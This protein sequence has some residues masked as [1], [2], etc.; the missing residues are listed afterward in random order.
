MLLRRSFKRVSLL[1]AFVQLL[2]LSN[3]FA[4]ERDDVNA[5]ESPT[6]GIVLDARVK[7]MPDLPHGPFIRLEDGR[8][9][10]VGKKDALISADEGKTWT[11]QPIFAADQPF[12]I[13][14]ERALIRTRSGAIILL[15]INDAVRHYSWNKEK[16]V[17]NP[18]LH[19]PSY[20][21]RSL[22]EGKTWT[23]LSQLHDGWCGCLQDVIQT[24]S[25]SI[26]VPGQEM[27]Y[28]EGRHATM[29]Y[30][31]ID[32]GKTW[33]RTRYLDIGGQ[34]DHAGAI[35]GTL[36]QL[37]DGRLWMLIRS[38]H[39][40]FY[41]SFSEDDGLAWT[42]PKRS[43]ITSTGSPGKLQRL[44][45]GRLA[46][47][48]NAL[49]NEGFVRREEL[50]LS[51]SDDE[52]ATWTPARVIARNKG[53]RVSYVHAFEATPGEL[54][55]TTM[56]G[57]LR[58]HLKETDF[59]PEWTR[60]VAFGDSTTATRGKLRIYADILEQE[61]PEGGVEAW[62]HNAGIPSN[63]TENGRARFQKDVLDREPKAVI[64][65]FGINDS[66]IDVWK[67]PAATKPRVARE[68]YEEN[69]RYFIG[70]LKNRDIPT[71]L[72]SPNPIRW[73]EK[74]RELY[75]KP[76]Y[77]PGDP[78][79]F[80]VLLKG[81][82]DTAR[83]VAAETGVAFIDVYAMFEAYDAV[84]GQSMD[85]LLLD[86]MHPN[87]AGHRLVANALMEMIVGLD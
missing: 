51:L 77:D 3:T 20:A 62:V 78:D 5:P 32:D 35:E 11:R 45:S 65:Q 66:A 8:I 54:W 83:N 46:L 15:F 29:P 28:K 58:V 60:I 4:A 87:D 68:R 48:W 2:V 76:P 13:R 47:L 38:Y 27:L 49:P 81:Y 43:K 67:N 26:V 6:K 72:M 85:D 21:I 75:G 63:T 57:D 61:L 30:V 73:V 17:P 7:A 70:E 9:M 69:L 82:A 42:D 41:E 12:E 80:N 84:A 18:D 79:G 33:Q 22:D 1:F 23:D 40:F 59:Q 10:G 19:L 55:V 24:K 31:S 14:P 16:N 50:S 37:K 56:Q 52:G 44:E 71:I 39:G 36:E 53:G 25:G 74:T 34:G 86:G 64:I